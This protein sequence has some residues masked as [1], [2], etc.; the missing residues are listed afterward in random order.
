MVQSEGVSCFMQEDTEEV[1]LLTGGI[2]DGELECRVEQQIS[3]PAPA[4]WFKSGRPGDAVVYVAGKGPGTDSKVAEAGISL[5]STR[6]AHRLAIIRDH[7]HVY[8]GL[9]S[10]GL[11][12]AED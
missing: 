6:G 4:T 1:V 11:E 12:R 2:A 9:S 5:W 7:S 10:P 8:V 3:G